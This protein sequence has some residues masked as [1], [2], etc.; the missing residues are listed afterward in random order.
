MKKKSPKKSSSKKQVKPIGPQPEPEISEKAKAELVELNTLFNSLKY[1]PVALEES[2][3]DSTL[4][5]L[6]EKYKK[7][8]DYYKQ[9]FLYIAYETLVQFSDYREPRNYGFYQKLNPQE[10]AQRLKLNVYRTM[11]DY[12]SSLEGMLEL[13]SLLGKIHDVPSAKL[14]THLFMY[15]G[16]RDSLNFKLL[17]TAV[18]DALGE[19]N[20]LYALKSLLNYVKYVDSEDL[21]NRVID[22]IIKWDEKI[23]TLGLPEKDT[24]KLKK[25]LKEILTTAPT[26]SSYGY[27]R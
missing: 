16:S 15:Y 12:S 5:T 19:S 18:I 4:S 20:S 17:R 8:E 13:I 3:K 22:T 7:G 26:D 23:E 14:L 9:T 27:V 2:K 24:Q 1:Y 25:E 11:F 21:L 10:K 6:V